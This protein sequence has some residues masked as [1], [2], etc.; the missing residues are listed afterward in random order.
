[1]QISE[2]YLF[3]QVGF[4]YIYFISHVNIGMKPQHLTVALILRPGSGK[5]RTTQKHLAD[6]IQ[7]EMAPLQT[8]YYTQTETIYC[9]IK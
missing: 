4:Y 3:I 2:G 1:M 5:V 9:F 7:I 6:L 8:Y